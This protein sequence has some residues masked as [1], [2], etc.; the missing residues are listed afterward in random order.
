VI[1]YLNSLTQADSVRF[2]AAFRRDLSEM[3]Y[4]EGQVATSSALACELRWNSASHA[5]FSLG[6]KCSSERLR[7]V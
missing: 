7:I 2:D 6:A 4:V 3:G 5:V 1:G